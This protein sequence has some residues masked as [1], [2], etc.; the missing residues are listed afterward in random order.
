[1]AKT[2]VIAE[3]PSVGRDFARVLPGRSRR[4]GLPGGPT[5]RHH[6]GGRP[7]R[8]ARRAR[9]VRPE[10]QEV[11]DGRPAD[12]ARPLQ[13]GRPRRA[14]QEADDG[15]LQAAEARRRRPR[16]Q[17]LRRRPRGRADLRLSFEKAAA[18]Q[19]VKRLWL[20]SM[21]KDGDPGRVRNLRPAAGVR[22]SRRPRARAR[23]PTGSWA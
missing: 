22:R 19:P 10:V 12:R 1:M 17:R 16:H 8:P 9:R 5:A 18:K 4:R 14:L 13:A 21:T 20:T 2:L 23:R 11:A 6:L 3:K 15:H 7:P